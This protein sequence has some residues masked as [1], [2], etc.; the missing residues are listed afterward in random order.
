M[1]IKM[2]WQ[3]QGNIVVDSILSCIISSLEEDTSVLDSG[4]LII[5]MRGLK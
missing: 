1:V 5:E 3:V 4:H 2:Q